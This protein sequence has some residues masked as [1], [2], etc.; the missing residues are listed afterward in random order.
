LFSVQG[1]ARI[2]TDL[3]TRFTQAGKQITSFSVVN[4]DKYKTQTGEQRED[5]CF[6]KVTAFGGL[7]KI[8]SDYC[9]KGSKVYISASLKQD[10][11]EDAQG[12]KKSMHSLKIDK[13]EML[14][15][16]QDNQQVLQQNRETLD[17]NP[18]GTPYYGKSDNIPQS[19]R[20]TPPNQPAPSSVPEIDID[21]DN[22]PF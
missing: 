4:S 7:A 9:H 10:K 19:A 12:N 21:A 11:W 5:S 6:V 8:I 22:I 1:V 13:L 14:D 20:Q 17:R 2:A 15:T 3:E 18:D 16:K